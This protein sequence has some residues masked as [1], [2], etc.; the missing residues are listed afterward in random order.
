MILEIWPPGFACYNVTVPNFLNLPEA[1]LGLGTKPANLAPLA[2]YAS[3]RA[4]SC[5]YCSAHTCSFAMR[6]GQKA[7]P[8]ALVAEG[9]DAALQAAGMSPAER[10]TI[11]VA[12]ALGNLPCTLT[13]ADIAALR[14]SL[15]E[16][17]VEWVVA[18]ASMFGSFNKLMDVSSLSWKIFF[19]IVLTFGSPFT[20]PGGS[21]GA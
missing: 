15:A 18:A 10:A 13:A 5:A 1:L 9:D 8:L 19:Y 4:A 20:G 6:R 2:M 3:S 17:D 12:R 14:A 21:P 7:G 11:R 16:V